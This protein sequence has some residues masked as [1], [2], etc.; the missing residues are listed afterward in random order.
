MQRVS[1]GNVP[2]PP[3]GSS[4]IAYKKR[5]SFF[6]KNNEICECPSLP[7]SHLFR[8]IVD[9]AIHI[10]LPVCLSV[11][12][13]ENIEFVTRVDLWL[14]PPAT[15]FWHFKPLYSDFDHVTN[16]DC[17]SNYLSYPDVPPFVFLLHQNPGYHGHG[18]GQVLSGLNLS[19]VKRENAWKWTCF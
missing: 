9:A 12:M 13:N 8:F 2:P 18:H 11:W 1:H 17:I 14:T 19:E 7:F 15:H 16:D 10:W 6:F 5:Q 4:Y 3:L